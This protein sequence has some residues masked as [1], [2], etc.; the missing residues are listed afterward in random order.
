[1]NSK[2]TSRNK[3]KTIEAEIQIGDRT[4]IQDQVICPV[5]FKVIKIKVKMLKN[6][7]PL[8]FIV[9]VAID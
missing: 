8:V 5:S 9:V 6:P 1:M 7:R 3:A 4:H 2:R